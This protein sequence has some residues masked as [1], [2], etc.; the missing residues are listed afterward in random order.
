MTLRGD[1]IFPEPYVTMIGRPTW[2]KPYVPPKNPPPGFGIAG[3]LYVEGYDTRDP[4]AYKTPMPLTSLSYKSKLV[5]IASSG[6]HHDVKVDPISLRRLIVWVDA[7]CPLHGSEEVRRLADPVFQGSEWLSIRP[8]IKS[9]PVVVR[10]GPLKASAGHD[11][12]YDAPKE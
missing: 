9:A 6:K 5:E 8:R 1:G 2:G 12:M 7:M 4:A 3:M 10:P 11:A